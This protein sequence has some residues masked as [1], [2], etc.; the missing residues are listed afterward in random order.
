MN[1]YHKLVERAVANGDAQLLDSLFEDL[2]RWAV[3]HTNK[4]ARLQEALKLVTPSEDNKNPLS[5]VQVVRTSDRDWKIVTDRDLFVPDKDAKKLGVYSV[6]RNSNKSGNIDLIQEE[7]NVIA[8]TNSALI[9]YAE[10]FGN[11][12]VHV[13][14]TEPEVIEN[15]LTNNTNQNEDGDIQSQAKPLTQETSNESGQ[16]ETNTRATN[17]VRRQSVESKKRENDS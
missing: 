17:P 15:V 8:A 2:D 14:P 1:D 13:T 12:P 16:A 9:S 6:S 3:S 7:A 10:Q 5:R 11:T 4:A